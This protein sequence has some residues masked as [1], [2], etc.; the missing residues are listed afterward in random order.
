MICLYICRCLFYDRAKATTADTK[1]MR[2]QLLLNLGWCCTR[3][4]YKREIV[5]VRTEKSD[6]MLDGIAGW[7]P[8]QCAHESVLPGALCRLRSLYSLSRNVFSLIIHVFYVLGVTVNHCT[9]IWYVGCAY[10]THAVYMYNQVRWRLQRMNTAIWS[11]VST[12][13]S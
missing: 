11:A 6:F 12:I 5:R 3:T 8:V 7:L 1:C 9:W 2:T 13:I 10:D 4:L